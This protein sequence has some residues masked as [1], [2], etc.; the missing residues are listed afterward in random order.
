MTMT[1]IGYGDITPQTS[2]EKLYVIAAML[3]SSIVFAYIM[4]SI[5]S[6]V[7]SGDEKIQ[8]MQ[9]EVNRINKFMVANKM[10]R[11][12]RSRVKRYFDYIIN[13]KK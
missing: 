6:F 5:A 1:T 2:T 10:P 7:Q 4:G 13:Y 3:V 12:F 9:D 11:K 8:N